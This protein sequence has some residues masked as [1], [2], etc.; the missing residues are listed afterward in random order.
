MPP[1]WIMVITLFA[2]VV[3]GP[4]VF[5]LALFLV[6]GRKGKMRTERQVTHRGV[7]LEHVKALYA[8]RLARD[9]F[10][11]E[12]SADAVKLKACR[13]PPSGSMVQVPQR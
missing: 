9:G 13:R 3:S 5:A 2:I 12:Y 11:P 6:P 7:S 10:T 4:L 8:A 1:F